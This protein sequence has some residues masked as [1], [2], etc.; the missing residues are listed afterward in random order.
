MY[1]NSGA[2]I[3]E[4]GDLKGKQIGIQNTKFGNAESW[5]KISRFRSR[6]QSFVGAIESSKTQRIPKVLHDHPPEVKVVAIPCGANLSQMLAAGEIDAIFSATEPSTFGVSPN[7]RHFFPDIK[8]I[9]ADYFRRTRIFPIMHVV[10]LR[11]SVYNANPW[12]AKSLQKAF[13]ESI[14]TGREAL[15]ERA[16]L[17]YMLPWLEDHVSETNRLMGDDDLYWKDG[18][19]ENRHVIEK[20]LDYHYAQGLSKRRF[21]AEEVC[22]PNCSESFVI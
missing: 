8:E 7:V 1:I 10:A 2:R 21:K 20:F 19:Y 22:A 3:R 5:K 17:R 12:I 16:A 13:A 6:V 14:K 15:E 4:P 18:F 11:R 9:E